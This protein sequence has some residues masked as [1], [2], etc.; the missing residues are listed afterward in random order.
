MI[1]WIAVGLFILAA[2]SGMVGLGVA[3][4]AVPFL[5]LF[6]DDLVNQVQPL[7]LL[8]NGATALFAA[9]GFARAGYVENWTHA[10]IFALVA[11]L[12]APVGSY[13]ARFLP[14]SVLW[15]LF[16]LCVVVLLFL[17][18][19]SPA[20][21]DA[22][23]DGLGQNAPGQKDASD[24]EN[25]NLRIGLIVVAGS[26]ILAAMLGMGPGFLLVPAL[27]GLGFRTK[28]AAAVNAVAATPASFSALAP[29]L[30]ALQQLDLTMTVS[31]VIVGAI[32]AFLGAQIASRYISEKWLKLI[33]ATVVVVMTGYKLTTL[34]LG[35]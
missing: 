20:Q 1:I 16:C 2:I 11:T 17:L 34:W 27:I 23:Q 9:I 3:F 4:A 12:S 28:N 13:I 8:L 30:S 21:P 26:T 25:K 33:F 14:Q 35:I 15:T 10:G 32:G 31:L 19:R 7:T 24:A 22:G 18:F 29:R 5:S 6:L